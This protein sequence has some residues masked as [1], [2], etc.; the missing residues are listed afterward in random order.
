[1]AIN[2]FEFASVISTEQTQAMRKS[3]STG[4]MVYDLTKTDKYF[5]L[6]DC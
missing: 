6:I 4:E 3:Y 5:V 2:I 1:M